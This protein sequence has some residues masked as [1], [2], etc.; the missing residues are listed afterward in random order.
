MGQLADLWFEVIIDTQ[1]LS[2]RHTGGSVLRPEPK[3]SSIL[4]FNTDFKH[5]IFVLKFNT[6]SEVQ[7]LF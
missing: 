6:G 1:H 5:S 3:R 4:I 2:I 7:P